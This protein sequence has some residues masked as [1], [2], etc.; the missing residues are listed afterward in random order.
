MKTNK[1]R[2]TCRVFAV[3]T[4]ILF[5]S[6]ITLSQSLTLADVQNIISQAVSKAAAMNTPVTVSVTDKEGNLLGSF[7]MTGAPATTLI[8]SVGRAGQG[9]ENLTVPSSAAANSKAGTAGIFSTG[10]NAFTTRTASFI[11]QEHFPPAIDN[12]PGGP[13]YGVQFST[14]PCSDVAIAGLPL[15]LSGDPGGL[16][17]Y[18]NGVAVG[19]VGVEADGLYTVD[20]LPADD[21]RSAE[22]SIAVY[23]TRGFEAPTLIRGDNILVEGIRLP[24][25]NTTET[26]TVATL[27]FASL[28]GTVTSAVI[29]STTT[30][31]VSGVLGGVSGQF[32]SRFPTIAGSALS[33][34]EVSQILASAVQTA[35]RTRAGIRQPI[36][37]NARVTIAVVDTNGTILGIFRSLDAPV[38]GLDVSVQKARSSNFFGRSDA[39]IK[40]TAAGFGTYVTRASADGIGLNGS[41]AFS[42]RA[43]GFLHRPLF[44]DGINGTDQGPF[45]TPLAD[46]SPF[47]VGLQLDLIQTA[48]TAPPMMCRSASFT[49]RKLMAPCP[50]TAI[51]EIKNGLQIFAGGLPVY[52]GSTLVGAVGVSGD[53]IDQD[54]LIAAAGANAF[55][56][57]ES[58][59]SDRLFVRGTRLPFLKFPAR[60]FLDE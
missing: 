31:F 36:G 48:L 47:N 43:I 9:L 1:M 55:A 56:P 14:L 7:A 8:R 41:V 35:N 24:F 17:L 52:R 33:A 10:G 39:G 58:I 59:R 26:S 46:W 25:V 37:S 40:L 15:G 34:S 57:A 49:K 23:A 42:D 44:P 13:L 60:P 32:S 29:A 16:P 54:D 12:R 27:S 30:D 19:G 51:P 4:A 38:F 5:A 21:D 45:S 22:E 2:K 20:R 11:I 50:C 28:P 18:K 3:F 53:G 6:Q